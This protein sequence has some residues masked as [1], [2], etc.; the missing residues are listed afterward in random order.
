MD[1]W[2]RGLGAFRTPVRFGDA[3]FVFPLTA[4]LHSPLRVQTILVESQG[5]NGVRGVW[6]TG[7]TRTSKACPTG[8]SKDTRFPGKSF[9]ISE[10]FS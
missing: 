5:R 10:S 6:T 4:M 9:P 8:E 7:G 3:F 1:Q 2:L